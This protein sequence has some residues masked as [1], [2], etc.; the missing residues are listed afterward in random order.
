MKDQALI[1]EQEYN[2][3]TTEI[4][5]ARAEYEKAHGMAKVE[6]CD[7][8]SLPITIY[9]SITVRIDSFIFN[10]ISFSL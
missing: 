9:S 2:R 4:K 8:C 7:S 6:S 1:V 3:M 5:K 10:F